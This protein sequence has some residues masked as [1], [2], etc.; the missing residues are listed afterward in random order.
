MAK[1]LSPE[2]RLARRIRREFTKKKLI[3][4]INYLL[5]AKAKRVG[6]LQVDV[7]KMD[8]SEVNSEKIA[9]N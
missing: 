7:I 3:G 5:P 1:K 9:Q 2:R 6:V 4:D 8:F